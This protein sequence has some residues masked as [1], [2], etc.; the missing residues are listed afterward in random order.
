MNYLDSI[1]LSAHKI[2]TCT[3]E[4]SRNA[5]ESCSARIVQNVPLYFAFSFM[6][7]IIYI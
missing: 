6:Q 7:W 5:E 3:H 2:A 4:V 1:D